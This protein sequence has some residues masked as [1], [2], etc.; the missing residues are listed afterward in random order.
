[1]SDAGSEAR[2]GVEG[3]SRGTEPISF[4]EQVPRRRFLRLAGAGAA[5]VGLGGIAAK[6]STIPALSATKH[7]EAAVESAQPSDDDLALHQWA[8]VFDLRRCDGCGRCTDACTEMHGLSEGQPW[9]KILE[10]E[11]AAGQSYYLPQP[12]MQCERP[13]CVSVCPVGAT[14]RAADGVT[15]V[16]QDRCIGCRMCMAACPYDARTFTWNEPLPAAEGIDEPTSPEFPVPQ[17]P[18]TAGKCVLCVHDVRDGRLPSCVLRCH[19]DAIYIGDLSADLAVN[20]KE[21]VRLSALLR[22]NDAFRLHEE[23]GTRP[24]V[25]YIP[26]H[27]QLDQED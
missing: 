11:D 15:L 6:A 2:T 4:H 18:G 12:C 23:L 3:T 10:L 24:R 21:T 16:D 14:F 26:G 7:A 1:M 8:M 9:L 13:P 27:G 19:R 5:L 22:D 20:G 17:Q 25:F